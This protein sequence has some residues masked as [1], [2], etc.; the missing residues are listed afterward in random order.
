[1]GCHFQPSSHPSH[2]MSP[3]GAPSRQQPLACTPLSPSLTPPFQ[4][5][6]GE[7]T[8]LSIK[9]NSDF[10]P[11]RQ[12][13]NSQAF[14]CNLQGGG[15]DSWSPVQEKERLETCIVQV[16]K[17]RSVQERKHTQ[18]GDTT[19]LGELPG[20]TH[21]VC[22]APRALVSSGLQV[23]AH[24]SPPYPALFRKTRKVS[25]AL[26]GLLMGFL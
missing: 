21:S 17:R 25:T 4:K 19:K 23:H 16:G 24:T 9:A 8:L 5:S 3:L 20:V 7:K 22:P 1:M 15:G 18:G 12:L 13:S 14:M 6:R 10:T 11:S 26:S 2:P